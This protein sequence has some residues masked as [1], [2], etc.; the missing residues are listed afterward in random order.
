M[1]GPAIRYWEFAKALSKRHDVLLMVPNETDIV[2]D[3]FKIKRHHWSVRRELKNVDVLISQQINYR[4][5]LVAKKHGVKIILDAYDP[6]PLENL[7]I[8]KKEPIKIRNCKNQNILNAMNFSFLAA[9][10]VIC[11]NSKQKD[12]W[13][14][15]MMALKRLTPSLYDQDCSLKNLIDIVPFGLSE[16]SPVKNGDGLRKMFNL[17][18][19]DKVIV[20]GGGIWNWFDP[21]SLI[22]AIK[23]LSE[24]RPEIKLVFMGVKHPNEHIPEMKMGA[25]ALKLSKE[26]NL[27]DKQVFFNFGW[28]PYDQRQNFLLEADIGASTH[29]EHLET[30]YAF[31]TRMLD[32]IWAGLPILATKGDSFAELIEA[33]NLGITIA[34]QNPQEI[35]EAILKILDNPKIAA[36][37]KANLAR[38]RPEFYWSSL[39]EPLN[40]LICQ[41]VAEKKQTLS[42]KD[43]LMIC[44]SAY[45]DRG[46]VK[47]VKHFAKRLWEM[48]SV[49]N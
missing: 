14:G 8:F 30:Q 49:P 41:L 16:I 2:S 6:M 13:L 33:R 28:V 18:E 36:E 19:R 42:F 31:R 43:L 20:W 15:Q 17:S 7:E 4:L 11:A 1:A 46:P 39:T 35:A 47:I 3:S 5:A 26:L 12:L 48:V 21:L 27:L 25:N 32:Y 22:K 34:Y 40:R 45:R 29:F 24:T 10:A 9:N 23:I 37:M 44:G 38:I